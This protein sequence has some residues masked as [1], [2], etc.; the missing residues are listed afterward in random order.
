[1]AFKCLTRAHRKNFRPSSVRDVKGE[2]H[3]IRLPLL[4]LT[5]CKA[6]SV[7]QSVALTG[8]HQLPPQLFACSLKLLKR[9]G[10]EGR[11]EK[12]GRRRISQKR[13][14][15]TMHQRRTRPETMPA[16][17]QTRRVIDKHTERQMSAHTNTESHR[18]THR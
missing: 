9:V 10:V 7:C 14:K 8:T 12:K 13:E 3:P 1:M 18:Q 6:F 17:T 15:R 2:F 11:S 4:R 5:Y 16:Y